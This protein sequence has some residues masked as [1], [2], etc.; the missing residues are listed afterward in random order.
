M[1]T[2]IDGVGQCQVIDKSGELVDLKGHDITSLE[3]TGTLTWEHRADSPATLV[4]KILKAKKI[5]KIDDCEN[6]REIYYWNKVKTPYLYIM[7]ELL[8]DYT[9]SAKECAGQMRYSRDNPDQNPLLGFSIE[10][11]ELP[12]TRKGPV[13]TRSIGRKVTLT[14]SPCN[15]ACI[16]EIYEE[17]HQESQVKDDF[18]SIFKSEA[19]AIELFKSEQGEKIYEDFLAKQEAMHISTKTP[20]TEYEKKGN[21][22]GT[23]R[24]GKHVVSHGQVQG[25]GFNP[26]E[27]QESGEFHEHAN[28][29]AQNPKLTDNKSARA[30]LH[31]Q[32]INSGARVN[33]EPGR[34]LEDKDKIALATAKQPLE[35]SLD[36]PSSGWS[37]GKVS[38][39][40]V[41]FSHPEHGTVSIQ[42]QPSGEFHVKHAGKLAGIGGIKGSFNNPKEAGAHAQKYM[43]GVSSNT[44]LPSSMKKAL[45]AGGMNGAPSTLVNGSAFQ[46]EDLGR[47][48]KLAK[49]DWHARAKQDYQNWPKRKEF[50]KFMASRMPHLAQGEVRAIGR[51]IALN[52][53]IEFEKSLEN[54]LPK[55]K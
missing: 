43:S 53:S 23:M 4:G 8:D 19:N 22:I 27:H 1:S 2:F 49:T 30:S 20:A 25:Y 35:K 10:G 28:V 24:S 5:F 15:S 11:S 46:V 34:S 41:H 14:Q 48:K 16:A 50:E 40:A 33:N 38:G 3:K 55:K 54:L 39:S 17:P 9:A 21:Q 29:T 31:S 51:T 32:Q 12:G 45:T 42:K 37:S 36:K 18:E 26:A 52:K 47:K 7:G 44:T 13:I 6:D